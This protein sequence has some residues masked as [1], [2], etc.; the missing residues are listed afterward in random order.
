MVQKL[1]SKIHSTEFLENHRKKPTDF[2]RNRTLTFPR[3]MSF[4][5]NALNGSI[6]AELVRFFNVIDNNYLSTTSVSTAAF[7]KARMKLSH[8]A[9]I[10]L[11]DDLVQTFY[12]TA[13]IDK[14]QG[15]RL[16]AVD[17][18][19]TQ[20]PISNE[21]LEHFG[22]A[23]SDAAMPHVRLSQLYDVK[24]N[25]TLDL[26]IESHST[27][28]REMA[29]KHLNKT[30]TGDLVV[31]DRGY[32]AVWFYKYHKLKNVD[33]CMRIVKSSNVVKAFL[34][35]GK[36]SDIVDFPCI[37]KSLRRCRKDKISTGS[38]RLRLVR[39][40]LPGEPE[41][42]VSSL[43]DL[44]TYPTALFADLYHQRWGVEEDYKVLKS[45]LNI[46]NYSSVSVEGVLQ[47]LH[48][49]LLTK[50]LAASAIHDAKRK[51]KKPKNNRLYE[52][53][54]NFTF[55]INQLKDNVVRFIMRV[56]ELELYELMISKI[57]K[58]LSVIRPDR[59]FFRQDRRN[60]TNKYPMNYKRMC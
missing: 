13:T 38:L 20:L 60:K 26:Q 34:A 43:T 33:F 6:Q 49:K 30:Q 4:M 46:E 44:Q 14:W 21:L 28:E 45:R 3:L 16:L 36:Y 12:D 19:V 48:A 18:S 40:D 51:I 55:A 58:N 23:R 57:S 22:K 25:I 39:V 31:Y 5:L 50:N 41:V 59:K 27:G 37:E 2:T 32:P 1:T 11:N 8:R 24:N 56:A 53:K 7:C 47:D 35:S 10:E 54:I 29:L 42:L 52:Y 15:H 17:G 9:F